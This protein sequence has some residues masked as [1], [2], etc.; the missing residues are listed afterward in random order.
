VA[1][2]QVFS[3]YFGF[4][5]Q[6]S[7]HQFLQS[8]SPI[9]RGWYSRPVSGCSTQSPTPQI[10]KKNT[11]LIYKCEFFVTL[12]YG[13]FLLGFLRSLFLYDLKVSGDGNQ[14]G[15]YVLGHYPSSCLY[16]KTVLFFFPQNTTFRKLGS[17]SILRQNQLCWTQLIEL[18]PISGGTR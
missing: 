7:F 17:V 8:P 18:I 4:P 5:C 6:S 15:C 2:G 1:L 12:V 9:I 10:K 16:L 11:L 14:Y 13:L 3:E